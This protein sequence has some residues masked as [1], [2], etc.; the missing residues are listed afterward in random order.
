MITNENY[1]EKQTLRKPNKN[2]L[3]NKTKE[4]N[5]ENLYLGISIKYLI[6]KII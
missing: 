4:Y 3:T 2:H 6:N 1:I 5:Y